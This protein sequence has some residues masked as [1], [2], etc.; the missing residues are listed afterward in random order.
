MEQRSTVRRHPERSVPKEAAE[1]LS[2]GSVAHVAFLDEAQPFVIPFG[3]YFDHRAPEKLYLHGSKASR[4]LRIASSSAPL[5]IAVTLVDGFVYSK[6]A[7]YHSINYRSAVCFG[8]GR[9]IDDRQIQRSVYE[10][11]IRR[12]FPDRVQGRDYA[13]ASDAEL[14]ATLLVEV[15]IEEW[16]AK[17]RQHGAAGPHDDDPSVP[18]TAGVL[19]AEFLRLRS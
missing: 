16:S 4:A 18:G 5:S 7:M 8:H 17:A 3:Y 10:A 15:S 19:S 2:R 11:F 14:D 1:I 9:V 12:Y 6:S 13:P